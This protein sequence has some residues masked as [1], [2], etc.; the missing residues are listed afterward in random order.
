MS[1]ITLVA[2]RVQSSGEEAFPPNPPA[3][4]PSTKK[5]FPKNSSSRRDFTSQ[6]AS[7]SISVDLTFILRGMLPDSP[8]QHF[9]QLPSPKLKILDRTLVSFSAPPSF[10]FSSI[11]VYDEAVSVFLIVC[12]GEE[13]K[14]ITL[15]SQ[16][17][18]DMVMS[19][20]G[21]NVCGM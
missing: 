21:L 3:S 12:I 8:R 15:G 18:Y 6:I 17:R 20:K 14:A 11:R 4:P 7:E 9:I 16:R 2:N 1:S 5:N 10:S 19:P 13:A